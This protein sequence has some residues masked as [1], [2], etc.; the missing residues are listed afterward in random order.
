M[1]DPGLAR[2]VL[3]VVELVAIS[4]VVVLR[5]TDARQY[6]SATTVLL[7]VCSALAMTV[8]VCLPI[9]F[10]YIFIGAGPEW[11]MITWPVT[12]I[13]APILFLAQ[14]ARSRW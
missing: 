10:F 2:I 1:Y 8:A 11:A 3:T 6:A 7:N 9:A 12:L 13:A 14:L 5:D 4:A